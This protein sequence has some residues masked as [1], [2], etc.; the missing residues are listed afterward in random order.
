MPADETVKRTTRAR[1]NATR[2]GRPRLAAMAGADDDASLQRA[3]AHLQPI[4]P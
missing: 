3:N 4:H 1:L 2:V